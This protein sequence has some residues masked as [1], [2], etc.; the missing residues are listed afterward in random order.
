MSEG[1]VHYLMGHGGIIIKGNE[2]TIN[3]YLC[4]S[5]T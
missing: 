3:S 2:I 4:V 1:S 5:T